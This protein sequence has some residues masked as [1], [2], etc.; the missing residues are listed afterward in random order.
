MSSA[1]REH[2]D[3]HPDPSPETCPI[4]PDQL[5]R[6]DDNLHFGW[7]WHRYRYCYRRSDDL[8]ILDAGCGTGLSTLGLARLNPRSTV[9]GLDCSHRSLD[10]AR[11][12][13][14]VS[15]GFLGEF[16]E[17]DLEKKLPTGLGPFGFVV[18]RRVL[19][20]AD[21]PG[22]ILENLGRVLDARGLLLAT[23][24]SRAGLHP[25]RQM[26]RAIEA[27]T[28]PEMG[29]AER[30]KVGVEL[31]RALR[32]DHP[33]RRCEAEVHGRD[34][35]DLERVIAGY[36]TEMSHDW[37]LE[38]AIATVERAGF[39]FLY[40]P[41]RIPWV[42]ERVFNK[43]EVSDSLKARVEGNSERNR[44]VL[45]DALDPSLHLEEYRVYACPADFDPRIPGWPDECR[46]KPEVIDRLIPHTTG[47]ARPAE[48]V[49]DPARGRGAVS[50]RV[51]TGVLGEIDW[52]ADILFRAIE[53][54]RSCAEINQMLQKLTGIVDSPQVAVDR[55]LN[56]AN[57]GFI[58]LESPD[59]RQH[60]DCQHLGPILDRLDCPCPRRWVRACERHAFCTIDVV[61]Q[62]DEHHEALQ[63]ALGRLKI[64]RVASCANC[65]D[66]SPEE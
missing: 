12:R 47:L 57:Y 1:V 19:G 14:R 21:D 31:F 2:Y 5:S 15:G 17:H 64:P 23:F 24:P 18:C 63:Q 39:Q 32:A 61:D 3:A 4:G 56:L 10:L 35:P 26:R 40:V 7:S 36:L 60:V 34:L 27:L 59:R 48:L 6:I 38:E 29:L 62:T 55:W 20:Q 41:Q 11:Q 30:A 16:R 22:R 8:R 54:E 51:V 66:Y 43:V 9:V 33:I 45:M 42:A 13:S 44:A 58:E 49:P 52:R 37:T 65:A 50:Y 46:H 25:A 53:G 28:T